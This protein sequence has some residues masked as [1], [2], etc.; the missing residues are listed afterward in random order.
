VVIYGK[1]GLIIEQ[2]KMIN[3]IPN[4][5]LTRIAKRVTRVYTED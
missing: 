3:S 4:E 2:S 5:L 1:E